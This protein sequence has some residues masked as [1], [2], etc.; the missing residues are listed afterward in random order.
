MCGMGSGREAHIRIG[1]AEREQ[2]VSMLGE[3]MSSG[4]LEL[5]E[6]EDRCRQAVA[7]R[8]R[9]EVEALFEDLPEP[10]PDLSTAVHPAA[11]MQRAG[12]IVS[13]PASSKSAKELA[14]TPLSSAMEVVAGTTF[15]F[16]IPGA[17]IL[18]IAY[19]MWWLFI[20]VV[21]VTIVAGALSEAFKKRS[22]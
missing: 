1:N 19:G 13:K 3:H 12:Q 5:A 16:G 21:A 22:G 20:P 4:R 7:A 9:A 15:I 18:T 2:A 8:T 14:A 6:Y 10:H 11:L 17:I